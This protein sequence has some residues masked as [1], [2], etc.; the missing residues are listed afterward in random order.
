MKESPLNIL[1]TPL[2]ELQMSSELLRF[3][4][5]HKLHSLSDMISIGTRNLEGLPGF[6]KRL[7]FEYLQL[8]E[9][10]GLDEFMES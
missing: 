1:N 8:L 5:A 3:A 2:E 9:K 4:E 7:L 6:N 10:H